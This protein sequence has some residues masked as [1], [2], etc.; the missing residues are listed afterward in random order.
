METDRL[1]AGAAL[2][3]GKG[4]VLWRDVGVWPYVLSAG[5]GDHILVCAKVFGCE[6]GG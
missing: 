2:Q 5:Y 6:N 1:E 4:V 3:L